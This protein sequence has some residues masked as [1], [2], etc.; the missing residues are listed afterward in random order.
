MSIYL[1]KPPYAIGSVPSLSGHTTSH[2]W[3]SLP[4]GH[5]HRASKAQGSSIRML[6]WQVSM[7]QLIFASLSHTH[8]WYEVDPATNQDG[9]KHYFFFGFGLYRQHVLS[10][11]YNHF[12]IRT[13]F[14][15]ENG[16]VA[17]QA[18]RTSTPSAII[19]ISKHLVGMTRRLARAG[20]FMWSGEEVGKLGIN[21]RCQ[22]VLSMKCR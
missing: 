16:N 3:R 10:I 12:G 18:L 14:I 11:F 13:T 6:L 8:Y 2:R 5:R 20:D 4:R 17:N 9:G 1:F 22:S 19:I 15:S 21:G 7:D